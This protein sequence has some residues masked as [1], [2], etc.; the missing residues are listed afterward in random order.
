MDKPA[1]RTLYLLSMYDLSDTTKHLNLKLYDKLRACVADKDIE[2]YDVDDVDKVV[3]LDLSKG[4]ICNLFSPILA[5]SEDE[6]LKEYIRC[7]RRELEE[8]YKLECKETTQIEHESGVYPTKEELV[9]HMDECFANDD[10]KRFIVQYC[11]IHYNCRANDVC[12]YVVDEHENLLSDRNYFVLMTGYVE[13]VVNCYKTVKKYGPKRVRI[14]D[15]RFKLALSRLPRGRKVLKY[16]AETQRK[17][18]NALGQGRYFKALCIDEERKG[19][20]VVTRLAQMAN[21]RGSSLSKI[22]EHYTE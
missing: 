6:T 15:P 22:N 5:L 12:A 17:T 20:N 10:W 18:Y 3:R 14:V 19:G 2:R 11:F 16:A 8:E 7:V 13:W 4:A 21:N 1:E 9:R